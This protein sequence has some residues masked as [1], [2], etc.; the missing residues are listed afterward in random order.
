MCA[1]NFTIPPFDAINLSIDGYQDSMETTSQM[2]FL[3][4]LSIFPETIFGASSERQHHPLYVAIIV[5]FKPLMMHKTIV[6][7]DD[8]D[9]INTTAEEGPYHNVE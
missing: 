3:L 2:S 8:D 5:L 9:I 7:I 6:T 4:S 1:L